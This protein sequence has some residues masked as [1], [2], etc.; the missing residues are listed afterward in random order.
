MALK[1]NKRM[2][3]VGGLAEEVTEEVLRDAFVPFG[4][5]L[6]LQLPLDFQTQDHKGF[7]F[8]EYATLEDAEAA[9]DNM[10][11]S[12]LYGRTLRVNVANVT[13]N[14][15]L[16]KPLW[17]QEAWLA[18][19]GDVADGKAA[20]DM[21]TEA[22]AKLQ[23]DKDTDEGEPMSKRARSDNPKVYLDINIGNQPAGRL[24]IELRADVVPK[25]AENFRQL[26][27]HA[28]G[29]GL[30]NSIFHR[31]I[32]GFMAQGGDFTAGNGTGGKSIYGRTFKDENF[33]LQHLG[34]G[35][36]SMAN[37]GRHT[38]GSQFFLTFAKTEW[39]D[40]K[41]VVFGHVMEGM[42][43]LSQLEGVGSESGKP[44]KKVRIVDAGEV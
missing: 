41:H 24:V 29:F 33:Q 40:G 44:S 20:K 27:T 31:I 39:L 11:E 32:P 4:D 17:Q 1:A 21:E 42:S 2:L 38:N 30:R 34:P 6:E 7:A 12:E 37:S 22:L 35:T 5:I 3:Y 43:L 13:R 16:A 15:N 23:S 26:C 28:K 8:I 36:L 25:T 14:L 18:E 10:H 19:H 9:I